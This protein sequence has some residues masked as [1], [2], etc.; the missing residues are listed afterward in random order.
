MVSAE[1]ALLRI[2]SLS[3][4]N[5]GLSVDLMRGVVVAA[6]TSV[7]LYGSEIW[8][9]GQ[10]D[11]LE[12]VQLLLNSQARAITGLLRSTPSHPLAATCLPTPHD[13]LYRRQTRFAAQALNANG[14]HPTHQLLPTNFRLGELCR[15]EGATGQPSSIDWMGPERMHRSFGGR[16]AQQVARHTSYDTEYGFE[17]TSKV[18]FPVTSPAIR[19]QG[20]SGT[21]QQRMQPDHPQQSTLFVS[22]AKDVS[23]GV[24]VAW[25]ERRAWK[26]KVSSKGSYIT[27]ADAALVAIGMV[28]QNLTTIL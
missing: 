1:R 11:R 6:V 17:L 10:K 28:M 13:L 25:R 5:V 8:W 26:T 7:A 24:G 14:N 2:S 9:R 23:F 27:A 16:L 22:T 3:R 15:H 12:E 21:L 4:S 19:T 18:D 20:S